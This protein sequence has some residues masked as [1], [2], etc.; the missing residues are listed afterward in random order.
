VG[1]N[2]LIKQVSHIYSFIFHILI[3]LLAVSANGF[4]LSRTCLCELLES[5]WQNGD[6]GKQAVLPEPLENPSITPFLEAT[7]LFFPKVHH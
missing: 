3:K 7:E 4:R 6:L 1:G 5:D 2:N